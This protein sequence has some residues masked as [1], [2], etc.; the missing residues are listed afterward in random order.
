MRQ[1]KIIVRVILYGCLG[2]VGY[3]N[4]TEKNVEGQVQAVYDS[5]T[6]YPNSSSV[7]VS[8]NFGN[9][10]TF[11]CNAIYLR[12]WRGTN[13]PFAEVQ[14]YYSDQF[15]GR[16]WQQYTAYSSR[17][18]SFRVDEATTVEL[19]KG[20]PTEYRYMSNIESPAVEAAK[21]NYQTMFLLIVST[22]VIRDCL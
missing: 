4:I 17:T 20:D 2:I 21:P 8:S 3:L 19:D 15:A 1:S 14:K 11:I 7:F 18:A 16:N 10:T 5:I 9:R 6:Q 12:N 22:Q 13:A